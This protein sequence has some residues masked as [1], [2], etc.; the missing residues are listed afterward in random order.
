MLER[1]EITGFEIRPGTPPTVV[2]N[3][4]INRI[5]TTATGATS[6]TTI[7]TAIAANDFGN[8]VLTQTA[9]VVDADPSV[10]N[11]DPVFTGG[12]PTG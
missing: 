8:T 11:S 10:F 4:R 3:Y 6:S 1:I 12:A 2:T 9:A 7:T 5:P